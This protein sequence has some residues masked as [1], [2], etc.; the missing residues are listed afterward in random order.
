MVNTI[1]LLSMIRANYNCFDPCDEP[2]YKALSVAI[3]AV[4]LEWRTLEEEKPRDGS[5]NIFT[6][7]KN[8]SVE[9]Y[10]WDAID[11]FYPPGR[12]FNVDDVIAWRPLPVMYKKVA[13]RTTVTIQE[14]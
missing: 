5:W 7:G 2:Y 14:G 13:Y 4:K 6:D 8:I 11:H 9:R 12:W 10:K 1:E 3:E